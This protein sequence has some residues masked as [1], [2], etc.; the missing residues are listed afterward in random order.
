MIALY[1]EYN[2]FNIVMKTDQLEQYLILKKIQ[3]FHEI[4]DDHLV[5][6]CLT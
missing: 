1:H 5:G 4:T 3:I 2:N 6:S